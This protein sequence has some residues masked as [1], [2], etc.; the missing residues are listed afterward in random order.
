[1]HAH[2]RSS[3]TLVRTLQQV[4]ELQNSFGE[5]PRFSPNL[6]GV[7]RPATLVGAAAE[8]QLWALASLWQVTYE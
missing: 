5:E 4:V 7:F 2:A 6:K 3:R 1:M 8:P